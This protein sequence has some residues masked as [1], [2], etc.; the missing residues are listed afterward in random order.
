M[1]R[2]FLEELGIEKEAI[3]K[4]MDANGKDIN[5]A[6]AGSES[7]DLKKQINDLKTQLED[8]K[9]SHKSELEKIIKD[10]AVT[11]ALVK[12]NARTEKAVRALIDMKSVKVD[13]K[14]RV[15]GLEE[16][17]EKLINSEET[18]YLFDNIDFKGVQPGV[19]PAEPE[20]NFEDMNYS[21]MCAYL[22]NK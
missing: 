21:Q 16:Q 15:S 20:M 6:K 22:E 11:N 2:S 14:G 12:A 10:N 13:E 5:N 9:A 3:D 18:G 1:K 7:E 8:T 17:L 19:S 4:I